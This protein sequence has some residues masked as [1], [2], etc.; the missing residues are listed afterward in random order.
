[1]ANTLNINIGAIE[2]TKISINGDTSKVIE[3]NL[4]DT[5]IVQRMDAAIPRIEE[6]VKVYKE[7]EMPEDNKEADRRA[8]CRE[9]V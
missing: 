3:L 2:R 5:G 9:R 7:A 4:N 8:S 1:M 6:A